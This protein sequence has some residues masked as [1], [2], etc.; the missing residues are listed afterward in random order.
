MTPADLV[1]YTID[2]L[3]TSSP[4]EVAEIEDTYRYAVTVARAVNAGLVE[5]SGITA[6]GRQH[7]QDLYDDHETT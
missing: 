3:A 4:T 2:L 5:P 6:E 7:M 1:D